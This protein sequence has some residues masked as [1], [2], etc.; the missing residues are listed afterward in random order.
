MRM[1]VARLVMESDAHAQNTL[2]RAFPTLATPTM[3]AATTA[4]TR[5]SS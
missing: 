4:L 1:K 5:A 2:P 3:P